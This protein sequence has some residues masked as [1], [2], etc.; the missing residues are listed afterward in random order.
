MPGKTQFSGKL[1]VGNFR[2]S[3]HR[4]FFFDFY[5]EDTHTV[6]PE[7]ACIP[8]HDLFFGKKGQKYVFHSF[9]QVKVVILTDKR[10]WLHTQPLKSRPGE[11]D[12]T[13]TY[14]FPGKPRPLPSLAFAVAKI[15]NKYSVQIKAHT[16]SPKI[17]SVSSQYS[18][19]LSGEHFNFRM[20]HETNYEVKYSITS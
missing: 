20:D 4:E 15:T 18:E 19:H 16:I 14:V 1:R 7:I 3:S 2:W 13:N 12:I 11:R 10:Y 8:S 5:T 17:S 6:S 9:W